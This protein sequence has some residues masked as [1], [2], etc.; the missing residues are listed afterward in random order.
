MVPTVNWTTHSS[1]RSLDKSPPPAIWGTAQLWQGWGRR[2][3]PSTTPPPAREES[4]SGGQQR[5]ACRWHKQGGRELSEVYLC[6]LNTLLLLH[7]INPGVHLQNHAHFCP[8]LL[9]ERQRPLRIRSVASSRGPSI[10]LPGE[11]EF[12]EKDF[13]KCPFLL[14]GSSA[15][16]KHNQRTGSCNFSYIKERCCSHWLLLNGRLWVCNRVRGHTGSTKAFFFLQLI[17]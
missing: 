13:Y 8:R 11:K 9:Q 16:S 2:T 5:L 1:S 7:K 10:W 14:W 15:W 3:A 12:A 6:V 4:P 17:Y